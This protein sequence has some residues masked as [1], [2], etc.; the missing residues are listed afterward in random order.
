MAKMERMNL[1]EIDIEILKLL[2]MN[3]RMSFSE[4]NQKV[5][6]SVSAIS[7]RIKKLESTG[8][9]KKYT[10]IIDHTKFDKNLTA[11]VSIKLKK[12]NTL[13]DIG[14]FVEN[15]PDIM[16]CFLQTGA[17]DCLMKIVTR[18][19]SSLKDI[20]TQLNREINVEEMR[21]N[22]VLKPLK[23]MYSLNL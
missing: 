16:E 3:S 14:S 2:Q 23:Q 22:I 7:E 9:I 11:L 17:Y 5:H 4:I 6:L 12:D 15:Q 13:D 8:V 18:D 1:D 19:T 10:T 21:T 20:L